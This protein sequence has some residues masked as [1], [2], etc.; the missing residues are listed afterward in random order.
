MGTGLSWLWSLGA[1]AVAELSRELASFKLAFEME[2]NLKL[3]RGVSHPHCQLGLDLL[4]PKRSR[5]LAELCLVA[6]SR[7]I[8]KPAWNVCYVYCRRKLPSGCKSFPLYVRCQVGELIDKVREADRY[9]KQFI[10]VVALDVADSFGCADA[11]AVVARLAGV[12]RKREIWFD[13]KSRLAMPSYEQL[14]LEA[15]LRG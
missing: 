8:W 5:N 14:T 15:A 12:C 3:A 2:A 9:L 7:G 11:E 13:G 6:T 10:G 1:E 4:S